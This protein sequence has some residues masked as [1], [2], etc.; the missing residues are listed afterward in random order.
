MVTD[1][2]Q[3]MNSGTTM[4]P[5]YCRL[6]EPYCGL[7]AEKDA[8]GELVRLHPNRDHPVSRGFACNK[9]VSF[10]YANKD[11]RR[12]ALSPAPRERQA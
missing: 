12:L 4:T 9:G 8:A 1:S 3:A 2:R 7:L 10:H 11:P 5:T 6:C